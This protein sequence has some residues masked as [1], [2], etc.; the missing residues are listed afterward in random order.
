MDPEDAAFA[1][2]QWIKPKMVIPIHYNSNPLTKGTLEE[3]E[4][5]MNGSSIKVLPMTEGQTVTF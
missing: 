5:A 3:F 1:V 4:K 2:R